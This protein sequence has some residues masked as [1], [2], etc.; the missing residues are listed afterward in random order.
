MRNHNKVEKYFIICCKYEDRKCVD[1]IIRLQFKRVSISEYESR[2]DNQQN[3][4]RDVN[5]N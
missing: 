3:P 4:Q 2:M 1:L 5:A